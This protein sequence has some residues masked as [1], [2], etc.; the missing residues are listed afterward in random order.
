MVLETHQRLT[1][2]SMGVEWCYSGVTV[3]LQWCYRGMIVVLRRH[4]S[5]VT[6]VLIHTH[7]PG[8]DCPVHGGQVVRFWHL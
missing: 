6:V 3:A 7:A 8:V 2:R 4:Y 5:G 1:V